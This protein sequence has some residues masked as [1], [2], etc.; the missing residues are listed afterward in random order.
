MRSTS[1]E[2]VLAQEVSNE[3][4]LVESSIC[5]HCSM[6]APLCLNTYIHRHSL[7]SIFNFIPP[8]LL[9]LFETLSYNPYR[10][11]PLPCQLRLILPPKRWKQD[12]Y[13]T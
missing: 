4:G 12:V 11:P 5:T 7:L 3:E 1:Y 2:F 13:S 8:T 9:R 6:P 10:N